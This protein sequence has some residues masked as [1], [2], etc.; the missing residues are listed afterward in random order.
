[1]EEKSVDQSSGELETTEVE[2]QPAQPITSEAPAEDAVTEETPKPRRRRTRAH[3]D[4]REKRKQAQQDTH[5][6]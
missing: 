1:M 3:N 4:P 2:P 5:S 6:E